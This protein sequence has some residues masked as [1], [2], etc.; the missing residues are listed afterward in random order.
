ML[1]AGGQDEVE[2]IITSSTSVR[3]DVAWGQIFTATMP[4]VASRYKST[5]TLHKTAASHEF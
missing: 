5:F 1:P 4:T 2:L 3:K